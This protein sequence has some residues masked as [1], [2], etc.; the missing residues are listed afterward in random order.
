MHLGARH[1]VREPGVL[2]D[3]LGEVGLERV[4]AERQLG[5]EL[6]AVPA[7]GL[8]IGEVHD[9]AEP[10]APLGALA[11][12]QRVV[13]APVRASQEVPAGGALLVERALAGDV[14][15]DP[16]AVVEPLPVELSEKPPGIGKPLRVPLEV[17]PHEG[18]LPERV[19]VEDVAGD[20]LLP[21]TSRLREHR[22][23][24]ELHEAG[25]GPQAE[26]PL[27]G[28]GR[29][30]GEIRVR[31][32]DLLGC[33]DEHVVVELGS[34]GLDREG[35][36][37]PA[38]QVKRDSRRDVHEHAVTTTPDEERD[39][40]VGELGAGAVRIPVPDPH[41]P[42]HVVEARELLAAAV[43]VVLG[44]E[45]EVLHDR[46]GAPGGIVRQALDL[47]TRPR[48][49]AVP[50]EV[51]VVRYLLGQQPAVGGPEGELPRVERRL[52]REVE[53]PHD[54]P[55]LGCFHGPR[56]D[57][58]PA[59]DVAER[60]VHGNR[61]GRDPDAH[62]ARASGLDRHARRCEQFGDAPELDA[63]RGPLPPERPEEPQVP[64]LHGSSGPLHSRLPS[65]SRRRASGRGRGSAAAR[66]S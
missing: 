55:A 58:G 9:A 28:D 44:I 16:E 7:D 38:A 22:A 8:G 35:P 20:A 36:V 15:V 56:A 18:A 52:D 49:E 31:R 24:G 46:E 29:L 47:E 4:R 63:A 2:G 1:P 59:D 34:R 25:G 66:S 61:A 14:R 13:D 50:G 45:Q 21:E 32:H 37:R 39:V 11:P 54:H 60:L 27:G 12:H 65:P 41:R 33:A 64:G 5:V 62:R 51:H 10:H 42:S 3:L 26:R 6:A 57:L 53:R 43:E 30:P 23:L 17:A 40:L 19:Q 48:A